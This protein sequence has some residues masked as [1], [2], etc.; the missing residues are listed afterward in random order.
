MPSESNCRAHVSELAEEG[1]KVL[2]ERFRGKKIFI[3]VDE[4]EI[5][6]SKYFNILIGDISVPEKTYVLDCSI[7]ETMS[8]Q[9]VTTQIDDALKKLNIERNNFVPL[10]SDRLHQHAQ[11]P[12]STTF[13]Y[14]LLGSHAAQ[15]C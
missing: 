1:I 9:V 3:A 11:D 7:A 6:G 10:V 5:N 14:D 4:N 15:L 8:Q 2:E 13:S 12:L